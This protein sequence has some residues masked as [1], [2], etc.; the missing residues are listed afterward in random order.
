MA[1]EDS[2]TKMPSSLYQCIRPTDDDEDMDEPQDIPSIFDPFVDF[3]KHTL[4][5]QLAFMMGADAANASA[6]RRNQNLML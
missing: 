2:K 6:L 3:P 5:L 1:N 4:D